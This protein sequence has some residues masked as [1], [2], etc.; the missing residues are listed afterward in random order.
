M[1]IQASLMKSFQLDPDSV[2]DFRETWP[3]WLVALLGGAVIA[4]FAA[5]YWW[6]RLLTTVQYGVTLGPSLLT[7]R[8][9]R[10]YPTA[11][12][13][14]LLSIGMVTILVG[15]ITMMA[16]LGPN[17]STLDSVWLCVAFFAILAFV[18][19]NRGNNKASNNRVRNLTPRL[20]CGDPVRCDS[21]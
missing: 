16:R 15:V 14:W 1:P 10:R 8:L 17:F 12:H 4:V 9:R 2:E 5:R 11:R 21:S 3:L 13:L 6:G 19:L 20:H 7:G 18:L